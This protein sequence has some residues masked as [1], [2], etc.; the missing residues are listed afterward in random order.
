MQISAVPFGP[1][2][3]YAFTINAN[4][5]MLRDLKWDKRKSW[6]DNF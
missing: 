1:R 6:W 5:A 2:K 3:S 4:S